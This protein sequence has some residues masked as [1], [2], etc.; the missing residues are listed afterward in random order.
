MSNLPEYEALAKR[1][2]KRYKP[3]HADRPPEPVSI[4][5]TRLWIERHGRGYQIVIVSRADAKKMQT[6]LSLAAIPD[7]AMRDAFVQWAD[8]EFQREEERT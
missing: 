6:E 7:K 8:E 5:P 2:R 3:W 1:M 4:R